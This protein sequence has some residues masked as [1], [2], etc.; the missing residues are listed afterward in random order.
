MKRGVSGWG[1]IVEEVPMD[2]LPPVH[3]HL[4]GQLRVEKYLAYVT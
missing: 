2:G 1:G 4:P 3:E